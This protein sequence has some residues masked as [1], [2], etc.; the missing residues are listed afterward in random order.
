MNPI[1][2]NIFHFHDKSSNSVSSDAWSKS[3][4]THTW[5]LGSGGL[6]LVA[7]FVKHTPFDKSESRHQHSAP[8]V[9]KTSCS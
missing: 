8:T 6:I 4:R 2:T 7:V 5:I 9:S 1:T 3:R